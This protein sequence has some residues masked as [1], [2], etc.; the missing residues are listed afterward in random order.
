MLKF[1][2][3]KT[4]CSGCAACYSVCPVRCITMVSDQ[5]GFLYPE[6]TN[7]CIDCKLCEKVCPLNNDRKWNEYHQTAYAA[8]SKNKEIWHRSTSGG[9]F[10]EIVR[11]WADNETLIVGASWNGIDVHHVGVIGF[12]NIGPLCKSK[13]VSSAIE[14]TFIQIRKQLHSDKKAVF[15]GCPCQVD[16]LRHFLVKEYENLLTIDLICH[17]QGSPLVFKE[18][19]KVI[20]EQLGEDVVSY[21]FRTKRK[22]IEEEYLSKVTTKNGVHYVLRDPYQQLFLRQDLLR[23]SC[24]DN[25]KYRD[26]RRPGDLTIADCRGITE[27]FPDLVGAKQNYSTIVCNTEKGKVVVERLFM[28]MDIREYSLDD[29]IKYNPLFAHHTQ[30]PINRELFFEEFKCKPSEA[31]I[32]NTQP[33]IV[34]SF[35]L[36]LFIRTI[37]P[38][39]LIK[40]IYKIKNNLTKYANRV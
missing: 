21:E 23:P 31:V 37:L 19:L 2:P 40:F 3:N 24:G 30:G 36:K 20:G 39:F 16:G 9:A 7:E 14:D 12:D 8:K 33:L 32:R 11:H 38:S 15:C 22:I 13:Y 4:N 25:C 6:A 26:R 34:K 17:G 18:C 1:N 5:E 28:T 35:N 27:I 29:V 10:S